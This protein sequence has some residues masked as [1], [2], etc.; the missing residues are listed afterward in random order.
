MQPL[1]VYFAEAIVVATVAACATMHNYILQLVHIV[2]L[3]EV[4]WKTS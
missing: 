1:L 4:K 2:V 3:G